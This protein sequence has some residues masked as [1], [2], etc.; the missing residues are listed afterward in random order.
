[1]TVWITHGFNVKDGGNSTVGTLKPYIESSRGHTY[2]W[3]GLSGLPCANRRAVRGILEVIKPG[4][5]IVAHSNGC[6]IAWQIAQIVP[7]ASVV[8][9]NPALR[10]DTK[11]PEG[12]PVLCLYNS[13]DWVVQLG[14]VWGRLDWD[15]IRAAGWGAAGRYGFTGNQ[16]NVDNWDTAM[17]WWG[18]PV[19]GHSGLFEHP[20][21]WGELIDAWQTAVTGRP[22]CSPPPRP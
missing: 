15:G 3:T 19:K 13:T 8:C 21:Y 6:L 16:V 14:R 5:S 2:G 20:D 9:I 1:M 7:L 17:E 12:L 22:P 4:D 18:K 11:W 10:R